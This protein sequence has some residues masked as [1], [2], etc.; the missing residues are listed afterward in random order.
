MTELMIDRELRNTCYQMNAA[1][2]TRRYIVVD[3][4][5]VECKIQNPFVVRKVE[6]QGGDGQDTVEVDH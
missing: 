1:C 3:L 6:E 2:G 4:Q 5:I